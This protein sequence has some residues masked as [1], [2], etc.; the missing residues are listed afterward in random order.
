MSIDADTRNLAKWLNEEQTGPIDRQALA[1]ILAHVQYPPQRTEQEPVAWSR[2]YEAAKAETPSQALEY[3]YTSGYSD[4]MTEGYEAGKVHAAARR[5]PSYKEFMEWAA[6]EGYDTAYA[7][8]SNTGKFIA[9]SPMTTDLW[10]AWQ[11]AHGITKG[12]EA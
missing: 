9:H 8:N 1:R 7:I 3:A 12:G 5:K 4:G 10:I 6:K 11:A 2:G